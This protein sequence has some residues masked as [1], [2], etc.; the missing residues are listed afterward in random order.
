MGKGGGGGGQTQ[1]E[2]VNPERQDIPNES[3][4]LAAAIARTVAGSPFLL[5]PYRAMDY[6]HGLPSANIQV[7]QFPGNMAAWGGNFNPGFGSSGYDQLSNMQMG[8]MMQ[9]PQQ[10]QQ[11]PQMQYPFFWGGMG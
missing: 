4:L 9:H 11:P 2:V 5:S 1:T 7:P 8:G 10:M 6:L 3:N